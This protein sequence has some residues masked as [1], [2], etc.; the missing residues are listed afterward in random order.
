MLEHLEGNRAV[1]TRIAQ[2]ELLGIASTRREL[3]R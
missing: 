2:R 1:D 3:E